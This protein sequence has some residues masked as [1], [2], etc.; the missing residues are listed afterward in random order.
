MWRVYLAARPRLC[1]QDSPKTVICSCRPPSDPPPCDLH[2]D[3]FNKKDIK[4]AQA[5]CADQTFIIDAFPPHD[6]RRSGATS[7]WFRDLSC[8]GKKNGTSTSFV[9]LLKPR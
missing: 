5:A 7:K 3:S 1:E 2:P 9:T 8:M 6:S 4:M